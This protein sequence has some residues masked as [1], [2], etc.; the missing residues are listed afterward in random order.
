MRRHDAA[1]ASDHHHRDRVEHLLA[2][3]AESLRQQNLHRQRRIAARVGVAF[4]LLHDRY[5]VRG[6]DFLAVEQRRNL[7]HVARRTHRHANDVGFKCPTGHE[8]F[9][10]QSRSR[11]THRA[12]DFDGPP[13]IYPGDPDVLPI[14]S[15]IWLIYDI[16]VV[17]VF[18]PTDARLRRQPALL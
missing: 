16:A 1:D 13:A 2:R 10:S 5:D 7:R 12:L 4:G 3:N 17:I 15:K 14:I 6:I 9:F 18:E 8:D 11:R